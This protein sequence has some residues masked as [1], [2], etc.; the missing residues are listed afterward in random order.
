MRSSAWSPRS[1]FVV[2]IAGLALL[3]AALSLI[4]RGWLFGRGSL[5]ADEVAYLLQGKAIAH[6]RLFPGVRQ[7]AEAYQP[8]FFVA[9]PAGFVSKY[10][11][12]LSAFL[13]VG[14][15]LG[16]GVGGVLA[17]F[18]AALPVVVAGVAR[19]AGLS[20]AHAV[21]AAAIVSLSPVVLIEAALPLTYVPFLV[22]VCTAWL[23]VL[24]I[25]AQRSGLWAAGMLGVVT[26]AAACLRPY[27]AVLLVLPG[28][29]WIMLRR[30]NA[31]ASLVLLFLVGAAPLGVATLAYNRVATGS[32]LHLPFGL[33]DPSDRLGFGHRRI[34]P[35][36]DYVS[37]GPLQGVVGA[38]VHF[39]LGIVLWLPLGLVLAPAALASRRGARGAQRL[40]LVLIAVH[41]A[42]YL[43]FWGPWNI[44]IHWGGA[45]R[46]LGPVYAMPVL[47][48]VVVAGLPVLT[49]WWQQRRRFVRALAVCS[50]TVVAAQLAFAVWQASI[51]SRRTDEVLAVANRARGVGPLLVDVDPPYLGNPVTGLIYG[52]ALA[53]FSPVPA[54]GSDLPELLQ[55]RRV[56]GAAQL[57][58]V[59][60]Q[61]Q[62]V[63]GAAVPIEIRLVGRR[64]DLLVVERGGH[65]TACALTDQPV[66]VLVTPAAHL[67]CDGAVVPARWT[68]DTTR[69]C[70]DTSCLSVAVYRTTSGHLERLIWRRLPVQRSANTVAML[71]DGPQ[72]EAAGRGW[73]IVAS[74]GST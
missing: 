2:A 35:E 48:M 28:L 53:T 22:L 65:S 59:V 45:N 10:L 6:G 15:A 20:R 17:V 70:L 61:Q 14:M 21:I 34:A 37:F 62:R 54:P 7:P 68:R 5:N 9:R 57:T 52:V 39:G 63:E 29:V 26:S 41:L 67:G 42:G 55:L 69:R 12:L 72:I 27:D 3:S 19:E 46:V 71:V 58:Y 51:D 30:K 25:G 43:V 18:A 8:W 40:L 24:R 50:I 13:A 33:V 16:V 47:A 44:S 49:Q 66:R 23:L 56:Y 1:R 64:A 73:L 11:P 74:P 31:L 60:T 32:A 4:L 38:V 36:Y